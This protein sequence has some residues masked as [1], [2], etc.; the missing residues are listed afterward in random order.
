M[1]WRSAKAVDLEGD[2]RILVHSVV[3]G[4][5]GAAGEFKVRGRARVEGDP[6]VQQQYADEVAAALGWRPVPGRFHLFGVAIADVTYIRY[7]EP[8][9]DQYVTRWPQS[10]EYVR[11]GTSATSVGRPEPQKNLLQPH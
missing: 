10:S 5:D 4:R 6:S 8:T 11:R 1:L 3:T 9:G 7:D 2:P